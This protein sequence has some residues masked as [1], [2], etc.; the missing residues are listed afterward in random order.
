MDCMDKVRFL[1]IGVG[2]MGRAHIKNILQLNNAEIVGLVDPADVSI[3]AAKEAFPELEDVAVFHDYREA[4]QSVAADAAVIV[5]PHS[6]HFEH[7]MACLDAGLH[8]LMEKPF[9]SGSDNARNIIAHAEKLGKHLA[10]GYQRHTQGVY[11]YL[12]DLVHRGD[13]GDIQFVTAYQAQAWLEG[14]RGTW[15]QDPALS[16]GGQLNDS[17][18]HLLDVVLWITGLEP[19][20]VHAS[21]D[22]C[23]TQVDI[24]SALTV[25]FRGGGICT[26]NV[27][28]SAT[29]NWWEDVS[30]HG[31]KGSAL[32]RNGTLMVSRGLRG[33]FTDIAESDLPSSSNPDANFVDLI[34]GRVHQAAAPAE[35]GYQVAR[36]TEAAWRSAATGETIKL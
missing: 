16:C 36:L 31:T 6:Q 3:R 17:G 30:I 33:E 10:V 20:E 25:R 27:V 23:G 34:Q 19:E 1:M 22:N 26:F 24:D 8:V 35:C 9:V 4:L 21:I 11:M 13:L 12:H 5:T 29:I 7:G 32:Y 2:G 28:G 18:S 15:R 14:C